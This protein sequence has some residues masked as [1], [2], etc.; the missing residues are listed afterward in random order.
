MKLKTSAAGVIFEDI[1]G[2]I[3]VLKR[4]SKSHEGHTWGL[5]GGTLDEGETSFIAALREVQEEIGFTIP[6]NQLHFL[7]SYHWDREDAE[8]EFDVYKFHTEK[9]KLDIELDTSENIEHL[10]ELPGKLHE[11]GDLMLGLYTILQDEYKF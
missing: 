6:E 4:H 9:D 1:D 11:R 7:K 3:L 8:I 5:V 10:W 2:T